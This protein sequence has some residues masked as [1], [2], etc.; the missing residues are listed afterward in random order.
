MQKSLVGLFDDFDFIGMEK[1][2]GTQL[3]R[4]IMKNDKRD[5]V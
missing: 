4:E 3:A 2:V 5:V 1:L